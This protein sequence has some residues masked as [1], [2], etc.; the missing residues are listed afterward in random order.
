ML[1]SDIVYWQDRCGG[2]V[3][4]RDALAAELTKWKLAGLRVA[5]AV[6]DEQRRS[7]LLALRAVAADS[8]TPREDASL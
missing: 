7:A 3:R 8:A 5:S 1:T 4:E 6:T 2:L